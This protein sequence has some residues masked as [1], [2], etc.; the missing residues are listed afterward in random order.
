MNDKPFPT[1]PFE[2]GKQ[3]LAAVLVKWLLSSRGICL[4]A[5]IVFAIIVAIA[6]NFLSIS[7][8]LGIPCVIAT[9]L[10]IILFRM[11]PG[12]DR[13]FGD[14]QDDVRHPIR[15][16]SRYCTQPSGAKP[17]RHV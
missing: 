15:K 12:E 11:R 13:M 3:G 14:T 1:V 17:R 5:P 2:S 10:L 9:I 16:T 6:C 4:I 7:V 8:F